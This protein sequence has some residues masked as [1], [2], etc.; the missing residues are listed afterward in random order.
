MKRYSFVLLALLAALLAVPLAG[1][2]GCAGFNGG[3]DLG[4]AVLDC[5]K[6]SVQ[7][8]V[9][10]IVGEVLKLVRAGGE[11]WEASLLDLGSKV[12][13]G[14]LQCAIK[15]AES[16]LASTRAIGDGAA[17]E[18]LRTFKAKRGW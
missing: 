5:A 15:M 4:S 14:T 8:K 9:G 11:G 6:A 13:L 7:E 1:A 10:T 12:G 2:P 3:A 18:R 17:A 16:E